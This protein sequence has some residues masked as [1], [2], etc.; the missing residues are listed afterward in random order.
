MDTKE[1]G[2]LKLLRRRKNEVN[3]TP[4]GRE[5]IETQLNPAESTQNLMNVKIIPILGQ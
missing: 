2:S 5:R 3:M 4:G 1:N